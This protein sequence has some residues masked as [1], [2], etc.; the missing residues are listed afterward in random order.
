MFLLVTLLVVLVG[1]IGVIG[2][3]YYHVEQ[4]KQEKNLDYNRVSV[5]S[6]M[7]ETVHF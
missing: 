1:I 5:E 2:F 4:L 3:V 7:V 6:E